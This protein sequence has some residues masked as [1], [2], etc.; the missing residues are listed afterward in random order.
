[1]KKITLLFVSWLTL[2]L[3]GLYGQVFSDNFD[4]YPAGSP[5]PGW[6]SYTT[7]SDDPG[8]VV[9]DDSTLARSPDQFLGHLGVDISQ[10]SESWIVSPAITVG[11]N[12]ELVFY[13]RIRWAYA[14][15]YTGV[16]VSAGSNDPINNPGDFIELGTF[17][18]NDH[19]TWN[20]W[21]KAAF[22]LRPYE[23][24]TIYIAFK[25]RGDFA[26]DFYVDDFAVSDIPYCS[27]PAN[28]QLADRTDSTLTV[29]W[30]PVQGVDVYEVVWGDPGF[31]PATATPVPVY[32]SSTY[33]IT[34]LQPGTLYEI[35]VRSVCSSYNISTWEGPVTGRTVGPPPANDT[36]DGAIELT[37][38]DQVCN[39]VVATN[40]DAT[41]S[42]V[43]DPGCANYRGGDVW[44]KAIVP[45]TGVL[46]FETSGAT[47]S[48]VRDTGMAAYSGDC[49]NLA[50]LDCDDD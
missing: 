5:P 25:Y 45:A 42:G 34:G 46:V 44:F 7:Q 19:P 36:C 26:H 30:E 18:P 41:D 4:S 16:Y 2:S 29:T 23:G 20:Q 10:T 37:V 40:Y 11:P 31:D 1:M 3:T 21:T 13:W 6:A 27:P 28:F 43:G 39:P 33:T 8:F 49:N 35:Y 48:D 14:Y 24:Q 32:N 47:G 15:D 22:D 17:D 9:I 50:Q 12:K 38:G